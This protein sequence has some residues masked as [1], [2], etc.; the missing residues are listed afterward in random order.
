MRW[1]E[2]ISV[3]A[4]SERSDS[5]LAL[6]REVLHW[7]RETGIGTPDDVAWDSSDTVLSLTIRVGART[8]N[9]VYNF[10]PDAVLPVPSRQ[11]QAPDVASGWDGTELAPWGAAIW[12][13]PAG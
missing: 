8:W 10:S 13:E 4:Q 12:E 11:G 9:A 7:R 5:V 3:A 2:G 6:Y 1:P